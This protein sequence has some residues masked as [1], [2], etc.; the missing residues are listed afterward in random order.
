M[1]FFCCFAGH[2]KTALFPD[3]STLMTA[4]AFMW[5]VIVVIVIPVLV[6]GVVMFVVNNLWDKHNCAWHIS[7][8]PQSQ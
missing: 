2:Q 6:M 3:E 5:C 1:Y 4:A 8:S 7:R